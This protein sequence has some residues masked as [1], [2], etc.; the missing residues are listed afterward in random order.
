MAQ[1]ITE[2]RTAENALRRAN[3]RLEMRVEQRTTNLRR[4]NQALKVEVQRR[5]DMHLAL[6]E[7]REKY[8]ALF[9]TFPIGVAIT[10]DEG[11]IVRPPAL[12][13]D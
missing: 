9:R 4:T 1:D 12:S 11:N 8:R 7:S 10:D 2:R 6:V 5:K 3:K 13:I